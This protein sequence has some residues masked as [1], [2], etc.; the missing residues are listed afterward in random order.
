MSRAAKRRSGEERDD[1]VVVSTVGHVTYFD[2]IGDSAFVPPADV[3]ETADTLVVRMELLGVLP[4]ARVRNIIRALSVAT[5][6]L[7]NGGSFYSGG[8]K[9][10]WDIR[11]ALD[12]FLTN[13]PQE[14]PARE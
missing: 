3:I 1:P 7:A 9:H 8:A 12:D 2:Q 11:R 6:N 4:Q 5:R 14:E 10:Y 13:L